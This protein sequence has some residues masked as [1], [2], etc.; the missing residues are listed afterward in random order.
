ML[1][2]CLFVP[3]LVLVPLG[4]R[5]M[6]RGRY[7][8][9]ASE[10]VR[11]RAGGDVRQGGEGAGS[12]TS[13]SRSRSRRKAP[14]TRRP[15][16]LLAPLVFARRGAR[17]RRVP[18]AAQIFH[19]RL[20][21][22][23]FAFVVTAFWALVSAGLLAAALVTAATIRHRRSSHR[24]PVSLDVRYAIAPSQL[25]LVPAMRTT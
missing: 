23:D 1:F 20:E 2:L 4:S 25:P 17:R 15:T 19:L 13:R 18:G 7:R 14:G 8:F 11:D 21:L 6:A 9:V 5:A 16:V 24:F 3:Q 10:T 22:P 12:R